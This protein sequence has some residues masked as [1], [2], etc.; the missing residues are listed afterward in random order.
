MIK[1]VLDTNVLI[2][3]VQDEASYANR[4]INLCRNKKALAVLNRPL[5]KENKLKTRELIKEKKYKESLEDFYH[6]AK[7]VPHKTHLKVVNWDKEDNKLIE[8]AIDGQASFIITEDNDLLYLGEHQNIKMVTPQEFWHYYQDE[9]SDA[10][11]WQDWAKNL[12]QN[13]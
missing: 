10:T 6:Q 2:N 3:G 11:E 5:L 13:K 9:E 7:M 8:A 12:F 1:I 4:I